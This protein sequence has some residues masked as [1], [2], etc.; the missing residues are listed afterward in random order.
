MTEWKLKKIFIDF[1]KFI[2]KK[3]LKIEERQVK[4]NGEEERVEKVVESEGR[5]G[6]RGWIFT[7][8]APNCIKFFKGFVWY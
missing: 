5:E 2:V 4:G 3:R 7:V 8:I 1:L 6:W